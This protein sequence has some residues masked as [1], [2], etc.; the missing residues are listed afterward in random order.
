MPI[1][2]FIARRIGGVVGRYPGGRIDHQVVVE[3]RTKGSVST[4]FAA[5]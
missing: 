5:G 2:G 4:F 3:E 1:F